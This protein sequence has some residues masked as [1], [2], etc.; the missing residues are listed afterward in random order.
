M[1]PNKGF[2][3]GQESRDRRKQTSTQR[4]LMFSEYD[5]TW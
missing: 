5:D 2:L 1:I 3:Q 4:Y